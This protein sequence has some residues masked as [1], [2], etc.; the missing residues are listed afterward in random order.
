MSYRRTSQN[1]EQSQNLKEEINLHN[2]QRKA[3]LADLN[4]RDKLIE[5]LNEKYR[6]QSQTMMGLVTQNE[7]LKTEIHNIRSLKEASDSTILELNRALA[8]AKSDVEL[9]INERNSLRAL[10]AQQ[11]AALR[12]Q[13]DQSDASLSILQQRQALIDK[14]QSH[15]KSVEDELNKLQGIL[16]MILSRNGDEMMAELVDLR[17]LVDVVSSA[18]KKLSTTN[19]GSN[20]AQPSPTISPRLGNQFSEHYSS[21]TSTSNTTRFF[22]SRGNPINVPQVIP[23]NNTPTQATLSGIVY[24]CCHDSR[25]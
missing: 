17:H 10:I 5:E 6:L 19:F 22:D 4:A 21:N 7:S 2:E 8:E 13:S 14:F 25:F 1:V 24:C 9:V 18:R 20:S 15:T 11:D 12:V 3:M 23:A 16:Q